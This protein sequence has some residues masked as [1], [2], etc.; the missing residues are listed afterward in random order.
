MDQLG[1][2]IHINYPLDILL[3]LQALLGHFEFLVA[4]IRL[5]PAWVLLF[6]RFAQAAAALAEKEAI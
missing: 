2:A 3:L 5:L 6:A 1:Y 4:Q